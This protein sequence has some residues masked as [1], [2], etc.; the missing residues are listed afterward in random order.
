MLLIGLFNDY[1]YIWSKG[2]FMEWIIAFLVVLCL[3]EIYSIRV[4]VI[5][6]HNEK[7]KALNGIYKILQERNKDE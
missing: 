6:A 1:I 2:C 7:M 4:D 3:L 5:R